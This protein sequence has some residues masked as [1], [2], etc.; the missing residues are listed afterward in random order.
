MADR[1]FD[2]NDRGLVVKTDGA[3]T[4]RFSLKARF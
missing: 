2:Y 3:P 1:R 4:A